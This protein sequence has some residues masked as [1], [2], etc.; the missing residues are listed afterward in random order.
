MRV[1]DYSPFE[2]LSVS[3]FQLI[4]FSPFGLISISPYWLW[5]Y[6][7][8]SLASAWSSWRWGDL[9]LSDQGG[10]ARL[11]THAAQ[12]PKVTSDAETPKAASDA[13]TPKAAS[14]AATPKV[15]S[16]SGMNGAETK[17]RKNRE[18]FSRMVDI[19]GWVRDN[20]WWTAAIAV[21][22]IVLLFFFCGCCNGAAGNTFGVGGA[23]DSSGGS[24]GCR[25]GSGS[26]GDASSAAYNWWNPS[27]S[28]ANCPADGSGTGTGGKTALVQKWGG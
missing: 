21:I 9:S 28:Q 5:G 15:G 18:F 19:A 6:A 12:T 13:E 4:S 25:N 20:P 24:G 22:V 2:I 11:E 26:G 27:A 23:C 7:G 8:P 10:G 17:I 16:A 1:L 14:E 3:P